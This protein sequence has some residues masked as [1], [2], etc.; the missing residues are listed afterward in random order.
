MQMLY[1]IGLEI[2]GSLDLT[3]VIEEIL[4][5]AI[6][7]VDARIGLLVISDNER[8]KIVGQV[9]VEDDLSTIIELPEVT[10]AWKQEKLSQHVVDISS[11]KYICIVPLVSRSE[12]SGLLIFFDKE[13]RNNT[14]GPFEEQDE[15]LLQSFAYQAGASLHNARLYESLDT[16]YEELKAAQ[17]KLA[18]MEQ[19]RALGELGAQV[20]H[21]MNHTLGIIAGHAD[22]YL[23]FGRD[24]ENTMKTILNTAESG[25]GVMERLQK[26]I[27]LNVGKKRVLVDIGQLIEESV[28]DIKALWL[29]RHGENVSHVDWMIDLDKVSETYA[30]PTDIKE[31]IS[32]ITLNALEAMPS[33]GRLEI[34]CYEEKEFINIVLIDT[35]IGMNEETQKNIFAPF[36]STNDD[37]GTGLGLAISYRIVADHNGEIEVSSSVD[38]GSC[39][40]VRLPINIELQNNLEEHDDSTDIDS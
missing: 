19:L 26:F 34:R 22:M 29:G 18:Q 6:V 7:M 33:G 40:T 11:G 39:F 32:N 23:S 31:V 8:A 35:G 3:Q 38:E 15:S 30:N 14:V 10:N 12:T 9:G 4:N 2:N 5:R 1:E 27:R 28:S 17:L 36:F 16:A 13:K 37:W 20:A 24:P 25:Q 21:A